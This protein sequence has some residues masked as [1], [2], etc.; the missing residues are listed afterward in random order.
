MEKKLDWLDGFFLIALTVIVTIAVMTIAVTGQNPGR[1]REIITQ[2]CPKESYV[3]AISTTVDGTTSPDDGK[4]LSQERFVLG[5]VCV[6]CGGLHHWREVTGR[7]MLDAADR[8][9]QSTWGASQ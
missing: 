4:V 8:F 7:E 1:G 2:T 9:R 3:I 5:R 6:N